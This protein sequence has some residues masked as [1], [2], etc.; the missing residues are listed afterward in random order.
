MKGAKKETTEE[1]SRRMSKVRHFDT[2]PE[3][4]VQDALRGL[5][6]Q[7]RANDK[8]LPGRP[9]VVLPESKQVIFIHGCFWH[10]HVGCKRAKR[11]KT[12][13][14][15]WNKRIDGNIARDRRVQDML[16]S[17]GWKVSVLW[18]CQ[19]RDPVSTQHLLATHVCLNNELEGLE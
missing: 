18:E 7:F 10:G 2:A 11:P 9:D 19:L 14:D 4:A 8:E 1:T 17:L 16:G 12:N 15:F 3:L 13:V 5:G 6:L